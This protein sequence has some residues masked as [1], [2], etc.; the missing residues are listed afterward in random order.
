MDNKAEL[1]R[2]P[3]ACNQKAGPNFN[4]HVNLRSQVK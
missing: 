2:D 3:V 4:L 1:M